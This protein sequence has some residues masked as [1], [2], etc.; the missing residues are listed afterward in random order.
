M[1]EYVDEAVGVMEKNTEDK[2]AITRVTLKPRIKFSGEKQPTKEELDKMHH[3]A[4]EN[5]F[6]ASSVK[7]EITVEPQT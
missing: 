5:C 2:L 4:H 1:D 3:A 6:I 7:T